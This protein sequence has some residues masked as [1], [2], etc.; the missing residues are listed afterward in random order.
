MEENPHTPS[1]AAP[2]AYIGILSVIPGTLYFLLLSMLSAMLTWGQFKNT[3]P[4]LAEAGRGLLCQFGV[5]LAFLGTTRTDGA[6]RVH[7]IAP[8]FAGDGLYAFI[9]PSLKRSDLLRDGRYA[10]HSYPRPNDE[11][12]FYIT[13]RAVLVTD[14]AKRLHLWAAYAGD[15]NRQGD[16]NEI[17]LAR[18]TI[19]ELHIESALLTR[20]T[21]HGDPAPKHTVW[22]A[23]KK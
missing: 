1:E 17:G 16:V 20:T 18:Q 15:E 4:D 22:H 2:G 8:Q 5:A 19:F 12:A 6:P 7:P 21:G 13:G 11:D 23:G 3:R 9:T 14:E 10:L